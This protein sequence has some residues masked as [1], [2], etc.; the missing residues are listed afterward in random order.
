M[1][2]PPTWDINVI[3]PPAYIRLG[4]SLYL[5]TELY[6][7]LFQDNLVDRPPEEGWSLCRMS[8]EYRNE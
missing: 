4:V 5:T 8:T 2:I 7:F 3:F 1:N 6:C